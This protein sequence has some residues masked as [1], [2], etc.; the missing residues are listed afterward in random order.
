MYV[1]FLIATF[2]ETHSTRPKCP[3]PEL[4]SPCRCMIKREE[5]QVW[6]VSLY[7]V[8]VATMLFYTLCSKRY[9][10]SFK[11]NQFELLHMSL[12]Y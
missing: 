2:D 12:R 11:L 6:Y 9:K 5:Y 3:K 8:I 4:I 7:S 1:I 10:Y